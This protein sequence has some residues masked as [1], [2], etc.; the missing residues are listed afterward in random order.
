MAILV[1]AHVKIYLE[2]FVSRLLAIRPAI[3]KCKYL[4]VDLLKAK[5][6]FEFVGVTFSLR[7]QRF[8]P[9]VSCLIRSRDICVQSP[10]S[11]SKNLSL[12]RQA[13][14]KYIGACQYIR[15]WLP[16][17]GN[18]FFPITPKILIQWV[19]YIKAY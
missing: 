18:T 6:K 16:E 8:K 9:H 7:F 12:F 19:R 17:K 14:T 15:P 3:F 10:K 1:L 11:H 5:W 4:K 13:W 2:T